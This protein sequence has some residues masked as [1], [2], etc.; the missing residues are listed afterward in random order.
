[1]SKP[2]LITCIIENYNI[3]LSC[4]VY[5]DEDE[6]VNWCFKIGLEY[7][8]LEMSE[9]IN[10]KG[11]INPP[12]YYCCLVYSI[13]HFVNDFTLLDNIDKMV[14]DSTSFVGTDMLTTIANI[15]DLAIIVRR[16]PEGRDIIEFMNK[17]NKGWYGNPKTAKYC[18]ELGLVDEHYV[19]WIEDIGITEYFL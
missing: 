13:S 3:T 10:S 4:G 17:A 18:I 16:I 14:V 8:A 11:H 2:E 19:P 1:M 5:Q 7:K 15:F 6:F 9:K 12:M